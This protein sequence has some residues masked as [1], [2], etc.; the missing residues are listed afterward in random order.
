MFLARWLKRSPRAARRFRPQVESLEERQVLS[1][2][3][4]PRQAAIGFV[5]SAARFGVGTVAQVTPPPPVVTFPPQFVVAPV[6]AVLPT[7][8][9]A[10]APP[11]APAVTQAAVSFVGSAARFGVGTVTQ[12]TNLTPP[13]PPTTIGGPVSPAFSS[14]VTGA[15]TVRQTAVSFV[16]SAA[17]FGVGTVA[18]VTPPPPAVTFPPQFVVAPVVAVFPT[19]VV[20]PAPVAP[21]VAQSAVSFVGSRSAPFRTQFGVGTVTQVTN[22]TPPPPTTIGGPVS[23]AFS[24]AV[25]G[26]GTVR[27]TAVS[28]VGN[29]GSPVRTQFGVGVV[30]QG[31]GTGFPAQVLGVPPTFAG[32]TDAG[33]FPLSV[34]RFVDPFAPSTAVVIAAPVQTAVP[35]FTSGPVLL[36]ASFL[37]GAPAL[38]ALPFPAQTAANLRALDALFGG[39]VTPAPALL[40]APFVSLVISV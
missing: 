16:G 12:V 1:T 24:S 20:A 4:A 26:A 5:G 11:P 9:V 28:F 38:T 17:R 14:A 25:T 27:Q 23:P 32:L 6:V 8:V 19:A 31:A 2:F 37:P 15:G 22:L 29:L 34:P 13:P 30:T 18:Q 36:P 35:F 33:F 3:G 7:P 21:A 39:F 10:P 40:S